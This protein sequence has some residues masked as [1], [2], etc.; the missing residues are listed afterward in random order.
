VYNNK[1]PVRSLVF[2]RVLNHALKTQRMKFISKM[3]LTHVKQFSIFIS[4]EL[5]NTYQ[6]Y[7]LFP[8]TLI[9]ELAD[10]L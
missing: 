10:N 4:L 2:N 8:L 3:L 6:N 9:K 7:R 1:K 5:Q